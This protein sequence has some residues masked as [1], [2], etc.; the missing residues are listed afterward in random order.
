MDLDQTTGKLHWLEIVNRERSNFVP[1]LNRTAVLMDESESVAQPTPGTSSGT[2]SATIPP[3]QTEQ[4]ILRAALNEPLDQHTMPELRWWLLCHGIQVTASLRKNQLMKRF[5]QYRRY[6]YS[7]AVSATACARSGLS[8]R[9]A[10]IMR[11]AVL[12]RKGTKLLRS[13]FT[14]CNQCS[15]PVV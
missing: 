2:D 4:D 9:L 5:S 3:V 11:T 6:N 14:I 13:R 7:C 8:H 12:F 10:L 1:F 15:L